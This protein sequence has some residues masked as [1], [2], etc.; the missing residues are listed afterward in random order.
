MTEAPA[1]KILILEANE[2]VGNRV[3]Q[4]L[5]NQGWDVT[6]ETESKKALIRLKESKP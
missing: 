3:V 5:E 1:P 6:Y 4:V 2:A